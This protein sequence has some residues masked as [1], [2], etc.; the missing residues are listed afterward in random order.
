[1]IINTLPASARTDHGK[2]GKSNLKVSLQK[3]LITNVGKMLLFGPPQKLLKKSQLKISSKY[4]DD[5][6]EA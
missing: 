5:N 4:V 3:L 2:K 1:M 6:N